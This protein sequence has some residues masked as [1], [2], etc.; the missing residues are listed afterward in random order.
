M[1]VAEGVAGRAR[2]SPPTSATCSAS[3]TARSSPRSSASSSARRPTRCCAPA[4]RSPTR[5]AST[6]A[7]RSPAAATCASTSAACS[8]AT[9]RWATASA[10]GAYCVLRDVTVG[11]GHADRAVL[12][13]RRRRRSARNCRIGPYARLRPGADARRRRAHRQLRR[14]EGEHARARRARPTTSPTSATRRSAA[15]VNFGAGTITCNYDG[16]NKHRTVIGDDVFIGSNCVLVAPVTVGAARRSAAA[17]RSSARRAAPGSSPSRAPRQVSVARLAAAGEETED[18]RR[19]ERIMCGIVG[20]ASAR[21]IVPILID[22]IRRLEYRGYDSTGL[23]VID[24]G[25]GAR[26]GAARHRTARVADLAAQAEARHLVGTTG[27][28][29]TRWATHGA[30]TPVNAHPHTVRRRDRRRAQRHHRELRGAARRGSRR[31]ATCSRRRPTPRSS[32]TSSTRTGTRAG[33]GDLLRAVQRGVAEF[34]GAYAIA[35][36]STREPGRVVGARQGSPL[37]VGLGEDDHF[38]ASDAAALLSVTRRVAY[39]EE[40]DV[41]DVRRES[42]RDLRRARRSASSAPSST[43]RRRRRRGR[44]RARTGTSCRRRSSSSRARSPTRSK[45]S[46]AIGPALFGA[47]GRS[48]AAAGRQRADPR[49]RHQLLLEPGREAVDRVAGAHPLHGRDRQRVPLPRQRAQ[50]ER[51]GRRRVAVGRDRRH[52]GGAEARARR[53]ATRTR[54][55]SATSPTSSMVRQTELTYLTRAGTEIGVASTKAFTTQLVAQFLL[56]LTLAKLRGRL[57]ADEEAHW[58]RG[59]A[60]PAGGAAGGA[61]A[62]A[63]GDRVGASSSRRSST[64][65]SSA[66]AC[67]TRSRSKAR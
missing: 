43:S 38:L 10:I 12:A 17:A 45:A 60:A 1:A 24:G 16:A 36:I 34:H 62:R 11:A 22:G 52:A 14:G 23:A 29:H 7:A 59:A 9:S 31:R 39:L 20:A 30:P 4:R 48:D 32:R 49:L 35:V 28:S 65:C 2:T 54:S 19:T 50:P 42:L 47:D 53:S 27:I 26:A 3:T 55:R 56:A 44:A 33:G 46:A 61:G 13:P 37:V 25:A 58:L 6:S 21:N 66:A 64:R 57:T 15:D 67:T 5:R 8:R 51:A 41:A 40:G 18:R 63:A